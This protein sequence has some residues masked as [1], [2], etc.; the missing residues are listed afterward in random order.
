MLFNGI[1]YGIYVAAVY[2]T[3]A[4]EYLNDHVLTIAGMF[5]SV[6]NGGGRIFWAGLQDR[7]GFKTIYLVIMLIQLTISCTLWNV[8]DNNFLYPLWISLSFLCEGGHFSMFPTVTAKIFGIQFGG[9]IFT[10]MFFF[11][12]LS[13]TSGFLLA[14]YV[15]QIDHQ[16]MFYIAGGLTLLN[17]ILLF[18]LEESEMVSKATLE[19]IK[20]GY[21]VRLNNRIM[22]N[23][24]G[25]RNF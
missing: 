11:I 4:Q 21:T 20:N 24:S 15:K 25:V 17:I 16:T 6:C 22:I 2:K 19:K 12:S 18:F 7:F 1:F 14:N 13:S 9:Q 3:T 23:A 8:K 5:G 10:M